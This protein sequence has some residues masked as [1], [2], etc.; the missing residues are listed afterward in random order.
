MRRQAASQTALKKTGT[1]AGRS[2]RKQCGFIATSRSLATQYG[3]NMDG[4]PQLLRIDQV[5]FWR[6]KGPLS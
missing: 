1:P 3:A 5:I 2:H 4:D 6:E